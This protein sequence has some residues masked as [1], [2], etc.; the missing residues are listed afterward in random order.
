MDDPFKK[1]LLKSNSILKKKPTLISINGKK[2]SFSSLVNVTHNNNNQ[3]YAFQSFAKQY[4]RS[5]LR[6]A[7]LESVNDK[8][9]I[10]KTPKNFNFKRGDKK[11]SIMKRA[12]TLQTLKKTESNI[13]NESYERSDF[14]LG[15]KIDM[16]LIN[17]NI[18]ILASYFKS[19]Y[20]N[21]LLNST[22]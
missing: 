10:A 6:N 17:I 9:R 7:Q 1:L 22:E 11:Q 14:Y 20:P 15:Q 3:K 18:S 2:E 4:G 13:T 12:K 8:R 5:I 16:D 21:N 19:I